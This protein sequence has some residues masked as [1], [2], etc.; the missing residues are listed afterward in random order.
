MTSFFARRFLMISA[1][2]LTAAGGTAMYLSPTAHAAEGD[3]VSLKGKEAPDFALK[4]LD[5]KEVK[6]SGLK[7]KVVL[8][9]FWATWCPPC[10][11]SLPHIHELS[12]NADHAKKGLVVLAVNAQEKPA[13]IKTFLASKKMA[14]LTV[15]LDADGKTMG[16]YKVQGIPTTIVVGKD[17]K[18][19]EVFVG[20]GP[21]SS[22]K[23]DA[24]IE[25]AL[26]AK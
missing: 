16:D 5:G 21:D 10:I 25:K 2:A 26:A 17:G 4:T 24:A 11:K 9:D 19:A 20:I 18:V 15:P 6:L 22:A 7:G 1:L 12:K 13:T 23:L 14:D 3:T 8:L